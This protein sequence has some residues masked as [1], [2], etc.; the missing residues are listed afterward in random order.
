MIT[1][2]YKLRRCTEFQNIYS[3]KKKLDGYFKISI[4]MNIHF[5]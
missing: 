1:S 3:K 2:A 4:I 5:L